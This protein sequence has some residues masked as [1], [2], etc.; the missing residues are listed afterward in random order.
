MN[1]M[2]DS[3]IVRCFLLKV[4][5]RC[6]INCDYCYMYNHLDQSWLQQPKLMSDEVLKKT[7]LRIQE[8]SIE[9]KLKRIVIVF[10]GG[11]PLL[12]GGK[13]LAEF[14]S[15]VRSLLLDVEVDF[16]IQTNGTLLDEDSIE[17]LNDNNIQISLS[18]DGPK[19]AN[20]KHRLDHSGKSTFSSV[21]KALTL[22]KSHPSIFSGVIAVIDPSNDPE[23]VLSYFANL[24]IP[25]L[26]FLLPDANYLSPPIRKSGNSNYY[27]DWLERCFDKWFDEYPDLKIRTFDSILAGLLGMP[28]D[29]DGFGFGDVSLI[30]IETDG[31]YHDLD[32]LK[33]TGAGTSLNGSS[34]FTSSIYEALG[35]DQIKLHRQLLKKEGLCKICQECSVVDICGGGAV[36]HRYNGEDFLQPSIYCDE[37]K[38]LIN[39]ARQRV[40]GQIN[41]E[42]AHSTFQD[43]NL[44]N[45]EMILE[46]EGVNGISTS[47]NAVL[48]SFK[49]IQAKRFEKI[50][51]QID[52]P[53]VETILALP[54]TQFESLAIQPSIV[55]WSEVM[56]KKQLNL[57]LCDI[58]GL[59]ISAET[60]YIQSIQELFSLAWPRVHRNDYWLRAPFGKSIFFEASFDSEG[61]TVLNNALT[62]IQ[63]WNPNFLDEMRAISPE[64]QFIRDPSAHPEKIVS[65]SDNSVPGALYVQLYKSNGFVEPCDL[66]DSLIHE[67]RHQKLYLLQRVCPIVHSDFPLVKS[68]WREELRPPT[69]LFHALY[70]FVCLL[71]FW[72]FLAKSPRYHLAERAKAE[73]KRISTQLADG[74][75]IVETCD[76]TTNGRYL[77]S[78]LKTKYLTKEL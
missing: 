51:K 64:I 62:L 68:P 35:T 40:I 30:T 27:K 25:Q 78:L 18:L 46:Y 10:H 34:I 24:S 53:F 38:H 67:H 74:F 72:T 37:L 26:D 75:D 66:A 8:Y 61:L 3:P 4:A 73:H 44:L 54:K 39:H 49:Q 1:E 36:P 28:S 22:L 2:T 52:T 70:V 23:E 19:M 20:D 9:Q 59:P 50:L 45:E 43:E 47:F 77:L 41:N 42:L 6:N 71:D 58:D 15:L 17:V 32:V 21:E 57:T 55:S 16:S 7:A 11:E 60:T 5:S 56:Y 76:L 29:T 69:G 12:I 33:I 14:A 65:F 13:K 63:D 48:N 31:S